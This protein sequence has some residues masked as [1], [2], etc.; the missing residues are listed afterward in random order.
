MDFP[1]TLEMYDLLALSIVPPETRAKVSAMFAEAYQAG[2]AAG[3][4][5]EHWQLI[6]KW[7]DERIV[8]VFKC[9]GTIVARDNPAR[10][11]SAL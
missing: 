2:Y 3:C 8:P 7:Y 11:G 1:V 6:Q 9:P 4:K 10:Q 5:G